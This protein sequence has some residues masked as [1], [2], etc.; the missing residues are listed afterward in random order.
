LPSPRPIEQPIEHRA[1]VSPTAQHQPAGAQRRP[2]M[3]GTILEPKVSCEETAPSRDHGLRIPQR[4]AHATS[5]DTCREARGMARR[6]LDLAPLPEPRDA[7]G[8]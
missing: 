1:F 8:V 4:E 5:E 3:G 7:L 2:A 6:G